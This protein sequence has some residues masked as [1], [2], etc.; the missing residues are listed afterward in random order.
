MNPTTMTMIAAT[1]A[2]AA[3]PARAHR[4]GPD[5]GPAGAP[6]AT[7]EPEPTPVATPDPPAD[8]RTA[9]DPGL[10]PTAA[11]SN[12]SS[13]SSGVAAA[14]SAAAPTDAWSTLDGP[15]AAG[16]GA[17][18]ARLA[19]EIGPST[20]EAPDRARHWRISAGLGIHDCTG[21]FCDDDGLDTAPFFGQTFDLYL[22][23]H[24]H[25]ALGVGFAALEMMPD[26][27]D[28]TGNFFAGTAGVQG[29][30]PLT[31]K[32]DL[33]GGLAAGYGGTLFDEQYWDGTSYASASLT[34]HGPLVAFSAGLD[35]WVGS[36]LTL[37]P[38]F[39]YYLTLWQEVCDTDVC[40]DWDRTEP[41]FRDAATLDYWM[42][43]FRTTATV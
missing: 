2:L 3:T 38:S 8:E 30:L 18:A 13:P 43:A 31:E 10:A 9:F 27:E 17:P 32:I 5:G 21:A 40:T 25:V 4:P 34:F 7:P 24:D 1:I 42:L 14:T 19:A 37:G 39:S 6:P 12:D 23:L 26:S 33:W 41:G 16:T 28:L 22:R 11:P 20:I 29:F 35:F 36:W 15:P